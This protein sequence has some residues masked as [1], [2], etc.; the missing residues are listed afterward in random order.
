MVTV[1]AAEGHVYRLNHAPSTGCMG[2][3]GACP[4]FGG[5]DARVHGDRPA[6]T[7]KLNDNNGFSCLNY[8]VVNNFDDMWPVKQFTNVL[9]HK[10]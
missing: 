4:Q 6:R 8:N 1:R 9:K 5:A 7:F 3:H 10:I 2:P